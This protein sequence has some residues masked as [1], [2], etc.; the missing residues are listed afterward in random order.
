MHSC[1]QTCLLVP[2][3]HSFHEHLTEHRVWV[4]NGAMN[5]HCFL[6][7]KSSHSWPWEQTWKQITGRK[8]D[9]YNN[10]GL[11]GAVEGPRPELLMEEEKEEEG[12]R[13]EA[14]F[15]EGQRERAQD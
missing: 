9:K 13:V 6:P 2:S 3:V 14:A 10:R 11:Y 15:P 4:G 7:R 12:R 8:C 1:W 5:K